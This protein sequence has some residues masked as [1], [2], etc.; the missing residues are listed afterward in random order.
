MRAVT[1]IGI[2]ESNPTDGIRAR[3]FDPVHGNCF[4]HTG[5]LPG[6]RKELRLERSGQ[7]P[8]VLPR[9]ALRLRQ[10]LSARLPDQRHVLSEPDAK[11]G[12]P[13]P[14]CQ[15]YLSTSSW[16]NVPNGGACGSSSSTSCDRPRDLQRRDLSAQLPAGDD[17][18][19]AG[20]RPLCDTAESCTGSSSACPADGFLSSG[21]SLPCRRPGRMRQGRNCTGS[22]AAFPSDGFKSPAYVCRPACPRRSYATFPEPV[23]GRVRHALW[24]ASRQRFAAPLWT[25]AIGPKRVRERVPHVPRTKSCRGTLPRRRGRM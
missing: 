10:R 12:Q 23:R 20:R 11:A 4:A 7:R 9:H 3:C 13:L 15:P 21:H 8:Q 19:P 25:Y 22:S 5:G 14:A 18:L 24:T 17:D 1:T 6:N 16:T 2:W